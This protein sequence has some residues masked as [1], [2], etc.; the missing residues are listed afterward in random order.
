MDHYLVLGTVPSQF[1]M[2]R[3]V[4]PDNKAVLQILCDNVAEAYLS[5]AFQ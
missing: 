1:K 4:G 5:T 2:P 3:C